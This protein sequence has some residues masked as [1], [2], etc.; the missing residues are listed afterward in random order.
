M[1]MKYQLLV[2]LYWRLKRSISR[3]FKKESK[4]LRPKHSLR[5]SIKQKGCKPLFVNS[6]ENSD[7]KNSK[8]SKKQ[9]VSPSEELNP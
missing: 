3:K 4:N 8:I 2:I 9:S 6:S 5:A 1:Q 7:N